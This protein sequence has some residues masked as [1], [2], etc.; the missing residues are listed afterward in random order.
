MATKSR[1]AQNGNARRKVMR[2]L[3]AQGLPCRICGL[4]IDYTISDPHDPRHYECDE[5]V[6]VSLGGSA[7]DKANVGPSHRFCNEWRGN[8][9]GWSSADAR[10]AL[11]AAIREW[12]S[13]K[14]LG[15]RPPIPHSRRW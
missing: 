14:G 6:P 2:W 11:A 5:I 7:L 8:R 15:R 13:R 9:M 12:T 3:K 10:V 4:P 1:A